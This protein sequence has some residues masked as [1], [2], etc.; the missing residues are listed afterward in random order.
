MRHDVDGLVW[1]PTSDKSSNLPFEHIGTF[2]ALGYVAASKR[3]RKFATCAP[4]MSY[5]VLVDCVRHV[6]LYRQPEPTATPLRNRKTGLKV[7]TIAKQQLVSLDSTEQI[8]GVYAS[9][10]MLLLLTSRMLYVL[11]IKENHE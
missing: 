10:H 2:N 3:E 8:L 9:N 4:D 6:Y 7:G 11:M 5:T 1:R